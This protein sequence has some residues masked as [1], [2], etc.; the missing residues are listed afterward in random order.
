MLVPVDV[1]GTCAIVHVRYAHD[2]VQA[3]VRV[4]LAG[5]L[6]VSLLMNDSFVICS[7]AGARGSDAK[8]WRV[9]PTSPVLIMMSAGRRD[10]STW[11][12]ALV[13]ELLSVTSPL[14]VWVGKT[15]AVAMYRSPARA[16]KV[17]QLIAGPYFI[18]WSNFFLVLR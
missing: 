7:C 12:Q 4:A 16:I 17:L 9:S 8:A 14:G 6:V 18:T 10:S 13:T 5:A 1:H 3:C 15:T 2:N 11:R